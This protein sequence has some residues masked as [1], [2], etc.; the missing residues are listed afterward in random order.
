ML[1]SESE[2]TS[3]LL[4]RAPPT[5]PERRTTT[6]K[7]SSKTKLLAELLRDLSGNRFPQLASALLPKL[8]SRGTTAR[9][10]RSKPISKNRKRGSS[11]LSDSDSDWSDDSRSY[12]SGGTED[13]CFSSTPELQISSECSDAEAESPPVTTRLAPLPGQKNFRGLGPPI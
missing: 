12:S 4:P 1:D 10:R 13:T 2:E 6:P 8:G 7:V 9:R 3:G 5:T 11:W